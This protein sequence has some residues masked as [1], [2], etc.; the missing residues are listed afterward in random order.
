MGPLSDLNLN[1]Q[2]ISPH[3]TAWGVYQDVVTN[4]LALRVK[5]F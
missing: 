4:A 2:Q 5:T 1:I 3:Q